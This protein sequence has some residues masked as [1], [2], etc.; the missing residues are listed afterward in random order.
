MDSREGGLLRWQW[1]LY[2]EGHHDRRNLLLHA[3]SNPLF[4]LGSI[5]VAASTFGGGWLG[6]VGLAA[7][8]TAMAAQG[9]GHKLE[10]TAPVPFRSAAD[11][12]VRFFVE[13]WVTFPRF[14]AS[15]RFATAWREGVP[16]PAR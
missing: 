6:L 14:V 9:R 4:L 5:A 1:S 11:L 13:Q 3:L 16:S 7:M 12:L 2:P 10:R 8:A 15:G